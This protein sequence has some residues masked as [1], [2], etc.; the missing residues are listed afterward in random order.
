ML[1]RA[2]VDDGGSPNFLI[3]NDGAWVNVSL[4]Y[5]ALAGNPLL[6]QP[7]QIRL[8]ASGKEID[9]DNVRLDLNGPVVAATP[10][11]ATMLLLGSG[12]IGVA[13]LARRKFRK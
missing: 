5:T 2:T 6:G 10:E 13:G 4:T 8:Y 11:P 1:A 9:F 3:S 7:L 12:L